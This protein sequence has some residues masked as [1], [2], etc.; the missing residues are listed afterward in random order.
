MIFERA[1]P[2]SVIGLAHVFLHPA[3]VDHPMMRAHWL[4]SLG[5][6][7]TLVTGRCCRAG[8]DDAM[9]GVT[10]PQG[11]YASPLVRFPPS[12]LSDAGLL[13][14]VTA[15]T[16]FCE[17]TRHFGFSINGAAHWSNPTATRR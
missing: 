3:S 2:R 9:R 7:V 5:S 13:L 16:A 14:A 10:E 15:V 11:R 8:R 17:A 12:P 4:N 1:E 6:A